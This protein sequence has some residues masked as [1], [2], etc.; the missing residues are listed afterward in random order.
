M[1]KE[2][3]SASYTLDELTVQER[4]VMYLRGIDNFQRGNSDKM[5][6]CLT[7]V[8]GCKRKEMFLLGANSFVLD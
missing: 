7:S 1:L 3:V 2:S 8:K 4:K 6:C 5:L